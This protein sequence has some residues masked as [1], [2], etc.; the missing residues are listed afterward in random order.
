MITLLLHHGFH[1]IPFYNGCLEMS[2]N[3]FKF[4]LHASKAVL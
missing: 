2:G 1:K 4:S 3:F